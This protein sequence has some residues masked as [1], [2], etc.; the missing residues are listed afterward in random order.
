MS[1][2]QL[3]T[4]SNGQILIVVYQI[5]STEFYLYKNRTRYGITNNAD[6]ALPFETVEKAQSFMDKNQKVLE[7]LI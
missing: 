5:N 3:K 4:H 6:K 1:E 2:F 7:D